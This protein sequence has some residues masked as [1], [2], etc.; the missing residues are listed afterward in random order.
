MEKCIN[1]LFFFWVKFLSA[2]HVLNWGRPLC[3]TVCL[4]SLGAG[5]SA[6]SCACRENEPKADQGLPSNCGEVLTNLKE[7]RK[8]VMK[9]KPSFF[10]K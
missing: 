6:P 3:L 7:C 4:L 1:F 2:H 10:L 8:L 9:K 5:D